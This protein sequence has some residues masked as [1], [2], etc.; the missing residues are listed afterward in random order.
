[1]TATVVSRPGFGLYINGHE[2]GDVL[3]GGRRSDYMVG[4]D[5]GEDIFKFTRG[6]GHD[7]VLGFEPGVDKLEVHSSIR[8][9]S[10]R[11]TSQGLE[12]YY[13]NFGQTGPDHFTL[14]HVHHVD[15]S[16]FVF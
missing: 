14:V 11:D 8:Q 13:G 15:M 12:V 5:G 2:D 1:M 6:G 3:Y 7:Y 4:H 9:I 10:F 16:D